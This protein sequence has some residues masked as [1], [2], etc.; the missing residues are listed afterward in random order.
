MKFQPWPFP[1]ICALPFLYRAVMVEFPLAVFTN[2]LDKE[3]AKSV[4]PPTKN[5][6]GK[7]M[8]VGK[9]FYTTREVWQEL[10]VAGNG[11]PVDF[12]TGTDKEMKR[13]ATG[14]LEAFK[15]SGGR[16]F[17]KAKLQDPMH[18]RALYHLE[19]RI[20]KLA[21]ILSIPTPLSQQPIRL[22]G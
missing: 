7:K 2:R 14:A 10:T 19:K 16:D 8:R 17:Y 1:E 3:L 18:L 15:T 21:Y 12:P 4:R 9:P 22:A 13:M 11:L 5:N 6:L 20:P